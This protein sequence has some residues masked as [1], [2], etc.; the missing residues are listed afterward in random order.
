MNIK[1]V[2]QNQILFVVKEMNPDQ[3]LFFCTQYF[4]HPKLKGI[5]G[6]GRSQ[7]ITQTKTQRW[8]TAPVINTRITISFFL[9]SWTHSSGTARLLRT[10]ATLAGS[11]QTG[12]GLIV[13]RRTPVAEWIEAYL[14]WAVMK[15]AV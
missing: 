15:T 7:S 12:T 4:S 3:T 2:S 8:D 6:D 14:A 10:R 1:N 13:T 9:P 11:Q 5:T